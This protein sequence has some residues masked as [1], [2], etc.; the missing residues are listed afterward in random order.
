MSGEGEAIKKTVVKKLLTK[1][2]LLCNNISGERASTR[3]YFLGNMW[4]RNFSPL[5]IFIAILFFLILPPISILC[6]GI[7]ADVSGLSVTPSGDRHINVDWVD[8]SEY[9]Y[10]KVYSSTDKSFLVLIATPPV[11]FYSLLVSTS[12]IKPTTYYFQVAASSAGIDGPRSAI[13]STTVFISIQY[14]DIDNDTVL[15]R[16]ENLDGNATNGF[17]IYNDQNINSSVLYITDMTGDNKVDFLIDINADNKPDKFWAPTDGVVSNIVQ[18]NVDFDEFIEYTFDVNGDGICEKF[19]DEQDYSTISFCQIMGTV[20]PSVAAVSLEYD[21]K[22]IEKTDTV[23]GNYSLMISTLDINDYYSLIAYATGRAVRENKI[24][25]K[26]GQTFLI[27][28]SLPVSAVNGFDIHTFPNPVKQ[29]TGITVVFDNKNEDA[30]LAFYNAQQERIKVFFTKENPQ[31]KSF[32]W[33]LKDDKDEYIL[34]GLYYL[35]LKSKKNKKI[36]KAYITK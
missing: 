5:F 21:G 9:D 1:F 34:P 36:F 24:F 16:A 22:V 23:N 7:P 12:V 20:S 29:G 33:N 31:I 30:T 25:L 6:Y 35:V 14:Y 17:E 13:V 28:F 26:H 4:R 8:V 3:P 32:I 19:F 10:Y 18:R 15:E 11:S 27:N 2:K